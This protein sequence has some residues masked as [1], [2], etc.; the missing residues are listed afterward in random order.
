MKALSLKQPYAE[1]VVAGKKKIELRNW[2]TKFRGEFFIH[3]SGQVDKEAMQ[4]FGFNE[5]PRGSIIGK[6]TLVEVK[7]YPTETEHRRDRALHLA[8]SDWGKYGF[9]LENAQRITPITAKGKL[10]FWEYIP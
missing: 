10:G 6:T 4:K 5:L 8:S 9:V 2:N 3:A 7:K 1:L